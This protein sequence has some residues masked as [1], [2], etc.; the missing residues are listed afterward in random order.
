M[1]G[2]KPEYPKGETA[3]IF[4]AEAGTEAT[5]GAGPHSPFAASLAR[6]LSDGLELAPM[7]RLV[8]EEVHAATN[9]QIR[10]C[11][12]A[13]RRRSISALH[14]LSSLVSTNPPG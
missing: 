7:M 8:A 11:A 9:G 12:L 10:K 5:D 14:S 3:I 4:S 1:A 2:L 13:A 6:H